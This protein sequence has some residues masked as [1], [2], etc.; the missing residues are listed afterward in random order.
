M[1]P[2]ELKNLIPLAVT[3]LAPLAAKY[4]VQAGDLASFLTAGFGIALGIYLHWNQK[5]VPEKAIV[6]APAA[7]K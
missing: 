3:A 2:D 5:K 7:S 6:V 1:N 4:G